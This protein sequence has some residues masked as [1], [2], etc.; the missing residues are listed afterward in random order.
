MISIRVKVFP[1]L[2]A[3]LFYNLIAD[4]TVKTADKDYFSIVII[5][6]LDLV[7][8]CLKLAAESGV[9]I[10]MYKKALEADLT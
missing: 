4:C 10:I 3:T 7:K 6:A 1:R 5:I 2:Y 8:Y 9:L